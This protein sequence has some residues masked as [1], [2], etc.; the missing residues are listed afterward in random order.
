M[1]FTVVA[2]VAY[3]LINLVVDLT[4]MLLDPQIR[5]VG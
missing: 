3:V 1:G 4:Y 5:S 2:S